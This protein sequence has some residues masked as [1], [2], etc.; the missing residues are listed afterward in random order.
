M[1]AAP[2][3]VLDIHIVIHLTQP[4]ERWSDYDHF[5]IVLVPCSA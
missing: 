4:I 1:I 3:E 5:E 2:I